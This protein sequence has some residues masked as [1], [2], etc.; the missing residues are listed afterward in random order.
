MTKPLL[1]LEQAQVTRNGTGTITVDDPDSP[2]LL[3]LRVDAGTPRQ[4]T[5]LTVQARHPSA[6]ITPAALSRLPLTQIRHLAV[7]EDPHP[8]D[9]L[10]RMEVTQKPPGSRHWP[11][12]HWRQV[13]AVHDWA[14]QTRRPGG[15]AQA[16]A[17][18]WNVSRN[19][20]AYRWLAS[21]RQLRQDQR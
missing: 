1:R 18:L 6:R 19:P 14:V 15:G 7:R 13:L 12:D 9:L 20:T 10:W 11:A 8:N 16:I 2:I 4:I 17:D 21:A 3:T 5:E